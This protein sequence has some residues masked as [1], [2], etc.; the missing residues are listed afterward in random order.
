MGERVGTKE[1][2]NIKKHPT[3]LI[4]FFAI[5]REF[6]KL[7]KLNKNIKYKKYI[8]IYI[9]IYITIAYDPEFAHPIATSTYR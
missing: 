3:K 7:K 2:K 6:C 5:L 8:Y 1:G 9:H 4:T